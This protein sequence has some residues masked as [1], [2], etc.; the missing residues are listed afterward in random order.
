MDRRA[1]CVASPSRTF[2]GK[3]TEPR[4]IIGYNLW[5]RLVHNRV[6]DFIEDTKQGN[7][8]VVVPRTTKVK[9]MGQAVA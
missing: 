4:G 3:Y 9:R 7:M 2:T 1:A 8:A 5:T 6:H